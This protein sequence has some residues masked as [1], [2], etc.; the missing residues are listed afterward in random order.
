M[1]DKNANLQTPA[2]SR[3]RGLVPGTVT[4]NLYS[5]AKR[6]R[7]SL[8]DEDEREFET[9]E[10]EFGH[11]GKVD[12][13]SII[14]Q[15]PCCANAHAIVAATR[16]VT[17]TEAAHRSRCSLNNLDCPAEEVAL[18][19]PGRMISRMVAQGVQCVNLWPSADR[20][21]SVDGHKSFSRSLAF[22]SSSSRGLACLHAL[23]PI[24]SLSICMRGGTRICEA[25]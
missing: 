17:P 9:F 12:V 22:T 21:S 3:K 20:A 24:P 23:S 5:A 18:S 4:P 13:V 2:P 7:M 6:R 1:N 14:L 19:P 16:S 10:G 11:A 8:A 15:F 25:F